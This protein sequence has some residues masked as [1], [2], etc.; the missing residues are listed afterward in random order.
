MIQKR[1][2]YLLTTLLLFACFASLPYAGIPLP[3]HPRPDF[4]RADWMN[5]NGPWQFKFDPEDIGV[6]TNWYD[7]TEAFEQEITVP[8]PWGSRLSGVEDEADIG[9]YARNIEIPKEWESERIFLI[10]GACD[11][12]TTVWLDG[13]KLGEHRGGYIPFEFELTE[14]VRFG[15]EQ[16]LVI[17]VDDKRRRF[18]LYGK[19]GYGNARG[20]WQTPYIEARGKACLDSVQFIPNVK[21]ESVLAKATLLEPAETDLQ[22]EFSFK[23]GDLT[24]PLHVETVPEGTKEIEKEISIPDPRLWSLDDPFLYELI[25]SLRGNPSIEDRVHTYFGMREIGVVNLPG[26][27]YSYVALNGK[28]VYLQMALDQAYHPEGYYTFPSD[29]FMRNEI[30]RSKQIGLNGMRVHVKVAIPRK[31]YWADKLGMLIMEDIPNSWSDPNPKMREEIERTL[32][33]VIKRDFNHPSTFSWCIFN[34]TWG[35]KTDGKYLRE[36]QKWVVKMYEWA[37]ELDPT[38]LVEDNSPCL[39]DHT[40]TDLNSWHA[41][42]SGWEWEDMLDEFCEKTYP[43]SGWNYAEGY[44]QGDE[45]MFNSECGNVWGYKGSTGDVDWTWDYHLMMNAF[46]RH[47]KCAGWLYTEHHDVINEWNGYWRY[48]RSEKITGLD[49][50]VPGMSLNDFHSPFYVSVGDAETLCVKVKPGDNVRVPVYLSIFTDRLP[51]QEASLHWR[52]VN[53]DRLGMRGEVEWSNRSMPIAA[54]KQEALQPLYVTFPEKEGL[55]ILQTY[56]TDGAGA[57][58][59]RNFTTFL[60]EENGSAAE[61]PGIQTLTFAPQDF[62]VAKW[63]KKHWDVL[64]GLKVNGAGAGYFEYRVAFPKDVDMN[65]VSG[66]SLR[67]EASAKQLFGK[68]VDNPEEMSGNYMTGGGAHDPSLN[69]NAYP[70]TDETTYPSQV[71]VTINGRVVGTYMLPDDPADHR[72]ILSWYAQKR[73]KQLREAGSYGYLIDAPIPLSVLGEAF[74]AGELVI[75]LEADEALPH[76]LAIYGKHFGRYPLDPTVVFQLK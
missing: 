50:I 23:A 3:E 73:D 72:G 60:A 47:P 61:E 32:P 14:H 75:R 62:R 65:K 59:H 22:I 27:D 40:V 41:Y 51:S 17:R 30:L 38:R 55:Y 7:N 69:P 26:T 20:I 9:W 4:M 39:Y 15:E 53:I 21:N 42:R 13:E 48:D 45:P 28:P 70:M 64:D 49:D 35:L 56:L 12:L 1:N 6:K 2:F 43:G 36:T 29:E 67:F 24:Q 18:T 44:K 10:I 19:Q 16:D 8:F 71:R 46:R 63:S 54:W 5:L 37:K 52:M 11:W 57:V 76:G 33:A 25:V 34:E 31:L 66:A 74:E 58:L 68:D